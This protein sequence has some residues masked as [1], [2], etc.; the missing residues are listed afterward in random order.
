MPVACVIGG[1]YDRQEERVA[2]RHSLLH[3]A[4]DRVWKK[5]FLSC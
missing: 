2:W 5:R 1:G 3:Q 4:A